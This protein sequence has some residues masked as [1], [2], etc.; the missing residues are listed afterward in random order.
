MSDALFSS[1]WVDLLCFS[2]LHG[3][4]V[5]TSSPASLWAQTALCNAVK[6][7][8]FLKSR[9][10]PPWTS[11]LIPSISRLDCTATE[12]GVSDPTDKARRRNEHPPFK[13]DYP[14]DERNSPPLSGS[15]KFGSKPFSRT[16]LIFS[17]D[18]VW[19]YSR[20]FFRLA[21]DGQEITLMALG[22]NGIF[23]L[24]WTE[25]KHT[26]VLSLE[27]AFSSRFVCL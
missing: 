18:P 24:Y 10:A 21:W 20:N 12:S 16:L 2:G 15:W 1:H 3:C 9:W 23:Q 17:I 13:H 5:F 22:R 27:R 19:M 26:F 14:C 11:I 25:I 4:S 6:P 7:S 8:L